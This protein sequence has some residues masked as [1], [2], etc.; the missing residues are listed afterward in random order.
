MGLFSNARQ[1]AL[2]AKAAKRERQAAREAARSNPMGALILTDQA[3]EARARAQ[4]AAGR[5]Q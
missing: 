3:D 4:R 1:A 2:M 5:R